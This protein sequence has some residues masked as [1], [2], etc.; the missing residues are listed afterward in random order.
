M[1]AQPNSAPDFQSAASTQSPANAAQQKAL[2][3]A[4]KKER[5]HERLRFFFG[6]CEGCQALGGAF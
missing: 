2:A 1:T 3:K 5:K 4:I 6:W